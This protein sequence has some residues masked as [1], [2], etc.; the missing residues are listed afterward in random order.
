MKKLLSSFVILSLLASFN[1]ANNFYSLNIKTIDGKKIDLNSYKDRK[2]LFIILPLN[3]NDSSIAIINALS[4]FRNKYRS[5]IEVIGI[6]SIEEGFKIGDEK[7]LKKIYNEDRKMDIIITEGM[8][9]KKSWGNDQSQLFKWL[10]GKE[11]NQHF[12]QDVKGVGH[13]FFVDEKGNLYAV[14]SPAASLYAPVIDKIVN[15]PPAN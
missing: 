10:T 12:N 14:L 8:K 13:K 9:V 2:I 1:Y 7:K 6:P 5:K 15:K 11:Q 3:N 4:I